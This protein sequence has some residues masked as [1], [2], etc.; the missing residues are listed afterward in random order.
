L[1]EPEAVGAAVTGDDLPCRNDLALNFHVAR[2]D[3]AAGMRLRPAVA[4]EIPEIAVDDDLA[5]LRARI[6]QQEIAESLVDVPE[7]RQHLVAA[8]EHHVLHA[9]ILLQRSQL[10]VRVVPEFG[11]VGWAL[12]LRRSKPHGGF[13]T[14][15]MAASRCATMSSASLHGRCEVSLTRQA[16]SSQIV[17]R[18]EF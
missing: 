1:A 13:L 14:K 5:L 3:D 8:L 9:S 11:I 15:K 4:T 16:R 6:G 2:V 7:Y 17:G 18:I 12:A 10:L